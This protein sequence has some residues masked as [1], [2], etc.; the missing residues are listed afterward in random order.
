MRC[1][2]AR[3]CR[4]LSLWRYSLALTFSDPSARGQL[5]QGL[6]VCAADVCWPTC[7]W[8]GHC[9]SRPRPYCDRAA[10]RAL[11]SVRRGS[12]WRAE[13]EVP[14]RRPVEP[15]S[16]QAMWARKAMYARWPPEPARIAGLESDHAVGARGA[17]TG[18]TVA[19]TAS[20]RTLRGHRAAA[21]LDHRGRA[22]ARDVAPINV[23]SGG[24]GAL[25]ARQA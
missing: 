21:A 18:A 11:W 23:G 9:R 6:A 19:E 25:G 2:E 15:T 10:D 14:R 24:N 1:A 3:P 12:I 17:K 22:G 20:I 8:I 13:R 5:T 7:R 4:A 16:K